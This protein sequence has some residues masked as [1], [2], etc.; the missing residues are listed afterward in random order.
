MQ[1]ITREKVMNGFFRGFLSLTW[2]AN[3]KNILITFSVLICIFIAGCA[4]LID[5]TTQEISVDSNPQGATVYVSTRKGDVLG[6]KLKWGET[7][8]KVTI[9]RKDGV[10]FLEKEGYESSE[11]SLVRTMNPWIWGDIL[12][13]S[14]LSTSIDTSTGASNEFDPNSYLV[15]LTPVK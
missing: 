14:L 6:K 12:L 15:E 13:T 4:S 9:P 3:M 8:T 5:G 10:I 2:E 1:T 7:P 11:V